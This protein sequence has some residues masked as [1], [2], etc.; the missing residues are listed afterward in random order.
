MGIFVILFFGQDWQ[1]VNQYYWDGEFEKAFVLYEQLYKEL[2]YNDFYFDCYIELFMVM[3]DY[4]VSEKVIKKYLWCD[5]ENVQIYVMYGKL[6]EWQVRS[7][8][9]EEMYKMVIEKLFKNQIQVMRLANVFMM[10]I[11]Y[12][13]VIVVYEWGVEMLKNRDV[14]VYDLGELYWCKGDIFKMIENYLVSIEVEF[15]CI[16]WVKF[17]LQWYLNVEDYLEV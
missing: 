7:D 2:N 9:V 13:L 12:D 6:L 11:K 15:N 14:F 8:E 10:F 16:I 4:D 1:L 3:D 17:I 5:F